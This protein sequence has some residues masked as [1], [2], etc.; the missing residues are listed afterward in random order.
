MGV[1][2]T[3]S[4]MPLSPDPML[5]ALT[6]ALKGIEPGKPETCGDK[7]DPI[8]KNPAI[9][10]TDLTKCPLGEKI[11]EMFRFEISGPG[12]VRAAL[13]KYLITL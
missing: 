7:L 4:P 2:D 6:E 5:S 8:L 13:Q 9:F 12:A 3:F 11:T 10:G 1:D